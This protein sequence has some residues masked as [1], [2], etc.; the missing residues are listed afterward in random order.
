M[1]SFPAELTGTFTADSSHTSIGFVARHA[2]VTKVRGKF[3][4]NSVVFT[5]DSENPENS[6]ATVSI[7]VNSVNTGNEQRDD[8]L[9]NNDFFDIENYPNIEFKS[10]EISQ[11]GENTFDVTGDLQIKDVTKSVTIP[12]TYEGVV[13]DP[14]GNT[15]VGFEGA[16]DVQRKDWNITWNNPLDGGGVLVGEKVR[17]EFE[18]SAVKNAE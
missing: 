8:H 12:F 11:T 4:D 16:V 7:L 15:R 18:I 14:W 1:S 5:L 13:T 9:R 2:M 10:T 3:D 17:L 6:T